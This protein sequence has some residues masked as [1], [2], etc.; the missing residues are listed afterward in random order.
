MVPYEPIHARLF[1]LPGPLHAASLTPPE[2]TH[3]ERLLTHSQQQYHLSLPSYARQY[4]C[5]TDS[6]NQK[7]VWVNAVCRVPESARWQTSLYEAKGG[8]SCYWGMQVNLTTEQ[9]SHFRK[10]A[11]R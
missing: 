7:V 3:L 6:L 8:G 10:N 11:S 2:V 9:S 4:I 1:Q 5:V